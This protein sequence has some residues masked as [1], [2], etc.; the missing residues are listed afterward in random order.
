MVGMKSD[1]VAVYRRLLEY[2]KPAQRRVVLA[3]SIA[4]AAYAAGTFLVPDLMSSVIERLQATGG[5]VRDAVEVPLA[6]LV[7]FGTFSPGEKIV[8]ALRGRP[9][10]MFRRL[11]RGA[12]PA[13]LG[14][15]EFTVRYHRDP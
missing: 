4:S 15:H 14:G 10:N 9:R 5:T 13:Q 3:A 1:V 7:L 11:A 12:V 2:L 6:I 8:E